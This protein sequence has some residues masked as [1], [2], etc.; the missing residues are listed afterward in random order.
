MS[1]RKK[2]Q[3]LLQAR[4]DVLTLQARRIS[5][6]E[7]K[8]GALVIFMLTESERTQNRYGSLKLV[9]H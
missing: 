4:S 1:L 9:P 6:A 2:L 3:T 7:F 5:R 8:I